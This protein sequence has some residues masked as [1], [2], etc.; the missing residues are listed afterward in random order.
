MCNNGKSR[1]L[2]ERWKPNLFGRKEEFGE[3]KH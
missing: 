3:K 2:E 1:F